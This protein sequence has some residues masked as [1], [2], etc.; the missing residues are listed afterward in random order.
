MANNNW[1]GG[2]SV[3]TQID[4][5]T[6]ALTWASG[7]KI[8][9]TLA[10]EDGST[11]EF[12][13]TTVAGSD[14]ETD[15]LDVHLAA[16]QNE[17][18]KTLF[19]DITWTKSGT[20]KIVATAKVG[21]KPFYLT[22]SET[23]AGDGTHT[24]A[25]TTANSGPEDAGTAANYSLGT[26]V[27]AGEDFRVMPNPTDDKSYNITYGLDQSAKDLKSFRRSPEYK[28]T[29]GDPAN[30]FYFQIDV[31]DTGASNV[32]YVTIYGKVGETWLKGTLDEVR[33]YETSRSRNA[34]K[35][36]GTI[37]V[38]RMKGPG[39]VGKVN[40]AS[41]AALT[42]F[43]CLSAPNA[44]YEIET[45]VTGFTTTF[46]DSGNGK[47]RSA[48]TTINTAW[49]A[50]LRHTAGAVTQWNNYN[51]AH[52]YYNGSGTLSQGDNYG[53]IFDFSESVAAAVTV[54][55]I[56]AHAGILLNESRLNNVSFGTIKNPGGTVN[57]GEDV[58]VAA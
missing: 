18:T 24:N 23:T 56:I 19:K 13:E 1:I 45:S 54:T 9:T 49:Q 50:I 12:V 36:D 5:Q 6:I 42:K 46:A 22:A 17:T 30:Q 25:S 26:V 39:V 40:V 8:K 28:G 38:L 15:V 35:L 47:I 21:G 32:P 29:I 52:V 58:T 14:I 10:S 2:A 11:T 3:A 27:A 37:G 31:S 57:L 53:G 7:D 20:D 51:G 43:Y 41:G 55:L 34:V 33:V 4:T 44:E 48:C 16:L